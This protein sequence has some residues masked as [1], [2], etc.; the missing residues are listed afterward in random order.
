MNQKSKDERDFLLEIGMEEM[1]ARFLDSTC[2]Q[3]KIKAQKLFQEQRL[4]YQEAFTFGT[5]R[6]LVLYIKALASFQKP[7]TQEVKGPTVKVAFAQDGKPTKAALGFAKSQ[8][9]DLK[10]LTVKQA[11]TGTYLFAVKQTAG[12]PSREVLPKLCIELISS[13]T[14]PKPMRWGR[15]EVRFI[16]PIRWLLALYG[17]EVI[18]FSYA[19]VTSGQITYGHRFLNPKPLKISE[20]GEYFSKLEQAYVIVD[21]EKRREKI[22]AEAQELALQENCRLMVDE[23]LLT[24]VTNLVEYPTVFCGQFEPAFLHLPQEVI[25]T[26]LTVHQRYFPLYDTLGNLKPKFLAVNNGT[27][28]NIAFVRAGNEKVL[29][30]RLADASFFWEEDLKTPLAEKVEALKKIVWQESLGSVHEKTIRLEKLVKHITGVL[31]TG[32]LITRQALRA[33]YLAKA[34]LVTSMVYEFPE[35][36]GVMGREYALRTNEELEVAQ[37]IFEHYRPRFTG[38]TLPDTLPG[39]ILSLADKLDGLTGF[40]AAGLKPSGSEDPYALR[41][42]ALGLCHLIME[43][44]FNLSLSDLIGQAY[45]GYQGKVGLKLTLPEVT[46]ELNDFFSQRLRSIFT[47]QEVSYDLIEAVLA[48]GFDNLTNCKHRMKALVAFRQHAAFEKAITAFHRAHNLSKKH[49]TTSLDLA[50]LN[51][52]AEKELYQSLVK[53]QEKTK[54]AQAKKDYLGVLLDIAFLER[55]ISNFFDQVMVMTEEEKL[56]HNRLGILKNIASLALPV[57]DLSKIVLE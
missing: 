12:N 47:E 14:F 55:P 7:E 30:A 52:P 32:A 53:V 1:P 8:G 40:F 19:D 15:L 3:L 23:E 31:Q 5:P 25:V 13:L 11:Q 44:E 24:E 39:C 36:Q 42:L 29:R 49:Q 48:A 26:P 35:L 16:R 17:K 20:P 22:W 56:R 33:A 34:D 46:A 21:Q 4:N 41:R 18:P 38:D 9:V 27:K 28:E 43:K 51:H 2:R 57:A 6:R 37:A 45:A 50:L 54:E 10:D